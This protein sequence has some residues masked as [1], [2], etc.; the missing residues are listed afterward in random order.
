MSRPMQKRSVRVN[1]R[2]TSISLEEQFV[3]HLLQIARR[4]DISLDDLVSEIDDTRN[5]AN[6]S[7]TLRL[8]VLADLEAR[9]A[10]LEARAAV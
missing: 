10:D 7:S 9:I 8:F 5:D 3:L 2:A 1:G 4:R 6:L